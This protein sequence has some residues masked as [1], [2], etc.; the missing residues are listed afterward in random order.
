[1]NP[2]TSPRAGTVTQVLVDNGQ[3]VEFDQ[4]LVILE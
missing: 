3:P 2:I 1:M 4:P